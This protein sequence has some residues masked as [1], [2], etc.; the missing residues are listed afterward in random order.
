MRSSELML[1]PRCRR[2]LLE[3]TCAWGRERGLRVTR[4]GAPGKGTVPG[5]RAV[6]GG[7]PP[8]PRREAWGHNVFWGNSDLQKGL[9]AVPTPALHGP[10]GKGMPGMWCSPSQCPA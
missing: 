7:L 1:W 3:P 2:L 9:E 4:R 5:D 10:A 6:P 8:C